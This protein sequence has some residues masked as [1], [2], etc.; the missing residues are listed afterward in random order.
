MSN[1]LARAQ[2]N[3]AAQLYYDGMGGRTSNFVPGIERVMNDSVRQTVQSAVMAFPAGNNFSDQ[4]YFD[5]AIPRLGRL[6]NAL[7]QI[8]IKRTKTING[9]EEAMYF[10]Q[11]FA[12]YLFGTIEFMQNNLTISTL[13]PESFLDHLQSLVMPPGVIDQLA[14]CLGQTYVTDGTQAGPRGTATMYLPLPFAMFTRPETNYTMML[15][16]MSKFRFTFNEKLFLA[17]FAGQDVADRPGNAN[18]AL[19]PVDLAKIMSDCDVRFIVHYDFDND[20]NDQLLQVKMDQNKGGEFGIPRLLPEYG[21]LS[22]ETYDVTPLTGG[23]DPKPARTPVLP[24]SVNMRSSYPASRIIVSAIP[25]FDSKAVNQKPSVGTAAVT[26][27]LNTTFTYG[28]NGEVTAGGIMQ[29]IAA[30]G[31]IKR[32]SGLYQAPVGSAVVGALIPFDNI[33]FSVTGTTIYQTTSAKLSQDIGYLF[34]GSTRGVYPALGCNFGLLMDG[35]AESGLFPMQTM[36]GMRMNAQMS[37]VLFYGG[38]NVNPDPTSPQLKQIRVRVIEYF[39]GFDSIAPSTGTIYR[40]V[41]P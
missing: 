10:L 40:N 27:L 19:A 5:L 37:D 13:L 18:F 8:D 21:V 7:L 24:F 20:F 16:E 34:Q 31:S 1:P 39:A 35:T 33:E 9:Q 17:S 15:L 12:A 28:A 11:G 36:P 22:D 25:L 29:G 3:S 41:I 23:G 4:M 26:P 2:D 14:Q 38:N 6:K 30:N 32:E